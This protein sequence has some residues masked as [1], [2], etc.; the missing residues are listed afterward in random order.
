ML[1]SCP[2]TGSPTRSPTDAP[3]RLTP[4]Q[5]PSRSPHPVPTGALLGAVGSAGGN[6][7]GQ[8]AGAHLP[9]GQVDQDPRPP[10]RRRPSHRPGRLP[11]CARSLHHPDTGSHQARRGQAGTGGGRIRRPSLRQQGVLV[12]DPAGTQAAASWGSATRPSVWT[13]PAS[14]AWRWI[15]PTCAG[16]NAS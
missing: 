12:Q 13:P 8:Q 3:P 4:L 1:P 10:A 11:R 16:W 6:Q 7:G 9:P 14:G 15:S 2:G 5:G